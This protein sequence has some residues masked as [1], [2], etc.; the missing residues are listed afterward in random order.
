LINCCKQMITQRVPGEMPA[1][2]L[3]HQSG[4]AAQV[5]AILEFAKVNC[6]CFFE[7]QTQVPLSALLGT[8]MWSAP[9]PSRG[10]GSLINSPVPNR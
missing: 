2:K 7:T 6:K 3:E 5:M 1:T 9:P 8:G 10:V 4:L